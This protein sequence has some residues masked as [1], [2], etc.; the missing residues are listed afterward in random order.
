MT[1]PQPTKHTKDTKTDTEDNLVV[2]L[3]RELTVSEEDD[4]L[5]LGGNA[6][7]VFKL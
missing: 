6:Q 4:A 3:L 2:E 5:I 1:S 7:K